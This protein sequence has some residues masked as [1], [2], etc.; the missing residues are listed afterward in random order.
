MWIWVVS[1]RS[2]Q[3]KVVY[4]FL[5]IMLAAALLVVRVPSSRALYSSPAASLAGPVYR[6]ATTK[7]V[8]ALTVNVVWGTRYVA[9]LLH[10]M[11]GERVPATFMLGGA[12]AQ[13]HPELVRALQ[14]AG[15]EIGNHG[16]AHRHVNQLSYQQNLT[17]IERTNT[18]LAAITGVLPKVF[19]PPYGEYNTTVLR[20]ASAAGMPLIMWTIDTVDWHPSSST[21]LIVTRVLR[22]L[23]PGAIV[24]MHPTERTVAALPEVI[25]GMKRRDYR[26]LTVS[27]LL[28]MGA[29]QGEQ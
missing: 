8:A 24:L 29:A 16:F 13:A 4:F 23:T 26:L 9:P 22:K 21:A 19:A 5:L 17:E 6:V 11:Q 20:A 10:I 18:A 1:L 28:A 3:A 14:Q 25:A 12:W 15:M 27:K 2:L 7:P